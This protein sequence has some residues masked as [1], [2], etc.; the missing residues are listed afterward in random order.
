MDQELR[1]GQVGGRRCSRRTE[2]LACSPAA[3]AVNQALMAALAQTRRGG[4]AAVGG[5]SERA[6]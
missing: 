6:G 2:A 1:S 5:I 3:P 4:Y